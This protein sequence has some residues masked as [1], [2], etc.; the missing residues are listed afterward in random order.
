MKVY[1]HLRREHSA[2]MAQRVT[3]D[4]TRHF[5]ALLAHGMDPNAA[6]QHGDSI[7]CMAE[8]HGKDSAIYRLLKSALDKKS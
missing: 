6:N 5:S 1:G 3:F 4:Q 2:S 8:T 7:L